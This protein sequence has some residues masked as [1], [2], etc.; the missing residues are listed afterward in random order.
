[1]KLTS[2]CFSLFISC[3]VSA[4]TGNGWENLFNGKDLQGWKQLNGKAIYEVKDGIITGTTVSNEPNSFLATE[5]DYGD[6]V[7]ELELKVDSPMNSG[8]QFRSESKASYNNGRVHGYQMEVDPSPRA[9]SGGVY[10]ESRRGWLYT[11]EYNPAAKTAFRNNAWNSYRIECIGNR[12]RTWVNNIPTAELIDDL[13]PKGF[14]ALQVH[15]IGKDDQPGKKIMW[16]NIRISTTALKPAPPSGIFVTNMLPNQL[17][18]EEI[19]NGVGLLWDGKTTKGWRG[20]YKTA[21]PE[22]GWQIHDGLL[23]VQESGGAESTHGGDIVTEQEYG[24]FELQFEFRLTDSAN[25]GV[26]YFVT[27]SEG[28]KGSAI[29]LEYQVLDDEKHPDAKMGTASNRTIASLY[30]LIPSIRSSQALR[31]IGEWN[32]G[33]IRVYPDNRIEHY[34]NGYKV[35]EYQRGTQMYYALVARSKYSQWPNF[36][37]APKGHILIQDHGDHVDYRSIKIR[38]LNV[39]R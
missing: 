3:L 38:M 28:N 29:G 35:I 34:L 10:D 25:S 24:A 21:F 8:I 20:A 32:R 16:R 23:S 14:I 13:T 7:L 30:D 2:F 18:P 26:K 27:E 39:Q 33:M 17:S 4:Q 5:K 15:S 37:M 31:K 9:W 36:G 11:M 12:I 19:K 22:T 6:F 1:M